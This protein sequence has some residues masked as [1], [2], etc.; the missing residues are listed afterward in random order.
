VDNSEARRFGALPSA[1]GGIARLAYARARAAGLEL[2]PLLKKAGLT[3]RQ[4]EDRHAR[5]NVQD[6]IRFLNLA[7]DALRDEF[8][9]FHLAQD[10]DLR[11]VGLLY[12]VV[13][14]SEVLSDALRRAERYSVIANEGISVKYREGKD[15][16]ITFAYVGVPRHSDRHQIEFW[17]AALVRV[18]RQLTNQHLLP[19]RV[20][21]GHRRS[22]DSSDFDKFL[23]R[24][25][26]FAADVDEVAFSEAAKHLPVISADPH[27]NELLTAYCEEALSQRRTPRDM[28]QSRVENLIVPLLPHGEA[29]AAEVA[30]RLG[31]SQRTL[32]RRLSLEG[33]TFAGILENLRSDLATRYLGDADLSVS[34]IAWLLGYREVSAFTHAFKRRTGTTPR[35]M[36]SRNNIERQ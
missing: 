16:A 3:E 11:E 1:A 8:L 31:M 36:R 2:E 6:Q 20:K 35:E 17:M 23:G 32:A 22:E 10:F 4:I 14:S 15:T 21:V 34:Q 13:A 29:R 28:L 5:L 33:L 26:M 30:R 19:V 27:L 25:A 24:R 9:G 12:Y 7:A 18:C